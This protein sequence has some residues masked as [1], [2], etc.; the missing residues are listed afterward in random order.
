MERSLEMNIDNSK[1]TDVAICK[2]AYQSSQSQWSSEIGASGALQKNIKAPFGFHTDLEDEPWWYVDLLCVYPID[3][4]VLHNRE[5]DGYTENTKTIKVEVSTDSENWTVIH[6]GL[7]FFSGGENGRPFILPL[8]GFLKARFV[9]LS[10]KEKKYFHL[11]KV[12][13]YVKNEE[14]GNS[15]KDICNFPFKKTHNTGEK[16]KV[17]ILG[18]SNSIIRGYTE[19]LSALDI[20]IV[21]NVSVGSSHSTLVPYRIKELEGMK[22]DVLVLDFHVNEQ[23]A[24]NY[25]YNFKEITSDIFDYIKGWCAERKIIPIVLIMPTRWFYKIKNEGLLVN[26]YIRFCAE[27]NILYFDGHQIIDKLSVLWS[28]SPLSFFLDDVH[29]NTFTAQCLGGLFALRIKDLFS[30]ISEPNLDIKTM[31]SNYRKFLHLPVSFSENVIRAVSRS[32]SLISVEF[33]RLSVGESLGFD[34][35]SDYEVVGVVINMAQTNGAILIKGSNES[36]KL[37]DNAYYD[38]NHSIWLVVWSLLTPVR[39]DNGHVSITCLNGL[40]VQ[41]FEGNDHRDH[42]NYIRDNT[43]SYDAVVEIQGIILR[44]PKSFGKALSVYGID[45]NISSG[46]NFNVLAPSEND[47]GSI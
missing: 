2:P 1:Y 28:R 37:L 22:F 19:S 21:A 6:E 12:K 4:I 41:N 30:R 36:I 32:T 40:N 43:S 31:D 7:V 5:N 34:S 46:I 11:Y 27:K 29:L 44:Y 10:L 38:P 13:V 25:Q 18:T 47:F 16:V 23:L 17:A 20:K 9:K 15:E 26:Y 14:L 35:E 39:S 3:S 24:E 8:S 42:G 33:A 45:L